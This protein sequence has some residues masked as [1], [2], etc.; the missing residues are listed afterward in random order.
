MRPTVAQ[1]W[2][3]GGPVFGNPDDKGRQRFL[4]SVS[5]GMLYQRCTRR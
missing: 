4:S 2:V 1:R 5:N 3:A